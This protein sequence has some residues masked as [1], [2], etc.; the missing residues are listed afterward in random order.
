MNKILFIINQSHQCHFHAKND[1]PLWK[2]FCHSFHNNHKCLPHSLETFRFFFSFRGATLILCSWAFNSKSFFFHSLPI[3][4][5]Q[6]IF[7]WVKKRNIFVVS[8]WKWLCKFP[9]KNHHHTFFFMKPVNLT[10]SWTQLIESNWIWVRNEFIGKLQF[11]CCFN[12]SHC[13]HKLHFNFL[14]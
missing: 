9:L 8:N 6:T 12:L 1:Y 5:T 3:F 2:L 13:F 10:I 4:Q 14:L 7:Q 11:V